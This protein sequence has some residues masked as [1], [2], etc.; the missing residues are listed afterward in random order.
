MLNDMEDMDASHIFCIKVGTFDQHKQSKVCIWMVTELE[1]IQ[2]TLQDIMIICIIF[3][4]NLCNF[5]K[6]TSPNA[7]SL[8]DIIV[9]F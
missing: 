7:V 9:P 3:I 2:L 4:Y 6:Q 1:I 8:E 5:L